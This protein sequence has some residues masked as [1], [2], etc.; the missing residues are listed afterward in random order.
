[1]KKITIF[2]CLV[3]A[4]FVIFATVPILLLTR[5]VSAEQEIKLE[6]KD[7]TLI[8]SKWVVIAR[9][10][11]VPKGIDKWD[12]YEAIKKGKVDFFVYEGKMA[13]LKFSFPLMA[14]EILPQK[15]VIYENNDWKLKKI[16]PLIKKEKD[17]FATVFSIIIPFLGIF[18]I[19]FLNKKKKTGDK[20]LFIFYI[21]LMGITGTGVIVAYFFSTYAGIVTVIGAFFSILVGALIGKNIIKMKRSSTFVVAF[22]GFCVGIFAVGFTDKT[23]FFFFIM[24]ACVFSYLVCY[25]LLRFFPQFYAKEKKE[26]AC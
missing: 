6:M 25:F 20:K 12:A 2:V 17:W 18:V 7:D 4:F 14:F 10:E 24:L 21:F 9:Y 23:I 13:G 19:T 15:R 1:M 3:I 26:E 16:K 5:N 8:V 11:G 22:T